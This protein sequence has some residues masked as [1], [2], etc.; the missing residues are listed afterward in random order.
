M[1]GPREWAPF[2]RAASRW[3]WS[4]WFW[5]GRFRGFGFRCVGSFEVEEFVVH[6][7][8]SHFRLQFEACG[9]IFW[10]WFGGIFFWNEGVGG[11]KIVVTGFGGYCAGGEFRTESSMVSRT[12]LMICRV[13]NRAAVEGDGHPSA[14]LAVDPMTALRPKLEA[15]SVSR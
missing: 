14:D 9:K 3:A 11:E 7:F 4:S 12:C 15:G 6:F 5:G 13:E 10:V 2:L 8:R 1:T